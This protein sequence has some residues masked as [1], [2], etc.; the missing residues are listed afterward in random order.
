MD[1]KKIIADFILPG[2]V[3][4]ATGLITLYLTAEDDGRDI[5]YTVLNKITMI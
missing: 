5:N 1:I 2:S 3:I 4:I